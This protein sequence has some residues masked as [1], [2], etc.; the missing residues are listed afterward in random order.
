MMRMRLSLAVLVATALAT[1]IAAAQPVVVNVRLTQPPPNQLRIADLWKVQL[2][3]RSGRP[4]NIYLH[5]TAE[6]LSVPD[7]IIADARST[8]F[9]V[10]PSSY[11]VTGRDVQPVDVDEYDQRYYDALLRTGAVPT[12]E[13]KICCEAIDVET[14]QIVGSDC[15]Y[16]T[17]S[18]L[19]VPILI[20]PPDE[21]EIVEK[22][23]VFTWMASVPPAQGQVMQYRLR[24]AEVFG[25]QTGQDAVA[26]NPAWFTQQDITRTILQYPISSRGFEV[27]RK[28]AW[29]IEAYEYRLGVRGQQ[30]A[31]IDHGTSEVWTFTY[32]PITA[33]DDE[34][35]GG[36]G[37]RS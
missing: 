5:G 22:Y 13:Y 1:V 2:D 19:S 36:A 12:G 17:V 34:D 10:Q 32:K 37:K 33:S 30:S 25:T 31:V 20:S 24:I 28:Y 3:N 23:P 14:G 35:Q 29:L 27:G 8:E 9:I 15:K 21:S 6:E 16:V 18:K 4:V 26:R 11:T 7:G